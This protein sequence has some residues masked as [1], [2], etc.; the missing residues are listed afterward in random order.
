M[1]MSHLE[2]LQR[3]V[4][5][6]EE[7]D[8]V[9][10]SRVEDEIETWAEQGEDPEVLDY[11]RLH[12]GLTTPWPGLQRGTV[13]GGRYR[14]VRKLGGG[15]MGMVYVAEQ[16]RVEREVA[17]KTINPWAVS[18]RLM[19]RLA[20]EISTLGRMN[21]PNIVRVFDADVHESSSGGPPVLYFTMEIVEGQTLGS[22]LTSREPP[23]LDEKLVCFSGI[24]KAVAFAHERGVIHRDLKPG[25]IMVR[26]DGTPAVLDFGISRV[27]EAHA[28]D[29]ESDE[30][31]DLAG[32]D[33]EGKDDVGS[34]RLMASGTPEY[35]SPAKWRREDDLEAGD[36]F[37]LGVI[38]FEMLTGRRPW[39]FSRESSFNEMREKLFTAKVPP[40]AG[41][42]P[43][44]DQ[45]IDGFV[46]RLLDYDATRRPSAGEALGTVT[47]IIRRRRA[48]A[49]IRRWIPAL[50]AATLVLVG[51]V[52]WAGWE[53]WVHT[54]RLDSEARYRE[55]M[56]SLE[57]PGADPFAEVT[58]ALPF[59]KVARHD[60]AAWR[61]A[62]VR[63]AGSWRVTPG[64]AIDVP[65]G[66]RVLAADQRLESL[67][68]VD[69]TW[70]NP[71]ILTGGQRRVLPGLPSLTAEVESAEFS[72]TGATIAL[73]SRDGRVCIWENDREELTGLGP[74]AT[75]RSAMAFSADGRQF[76]CG[77]ID[78]ENR[79]DA[80]VR[81]WKSGDWE[82]PA[83]LK[84]RIDSTAPL[85]EQIAFRDVRR[86]AFSEDGRYLAAAGDRPYV[87][88]W[89]TSK[90]TVHAVLHHFDAV[91]GIAWNSETDGHLLATGQ[92][93]GVVRVWDLASSRPDEGT[94]RHDPAFTFGSSEGEDAYLKG[95]RPADELAAL[96]WLKGGAEVA[97]VYEG[98]DVLTWG[99][100]RRQAPGRS[101][102]IGEIDEGYR[103]QWHRSGT[104]LTAAS[105]ETGGAIRVWHWED[106]RGGARF[107]LT[108]PSEWVVC[109]GD[110]KL[111]FAGGDRG[112]SVIDLASK[113]AVGTFNESL[114][115]PGAF[116]P[117]SGDLWV[118]TW[119]REIVRVDHTQ[120][121]SSVPREP[122]GETAWSSERSWVRIAFAPA[123]GSVA[124]S[125][126]KVVYFT[127]GDRLAELEKLEG[128]VPSLQL[129]TASD[130]RL[131]LHPDGNW[132]AVETRGEEGNGLYRRGA[133]TPWAQASGFPKLRSASLAFGHDMETI[134][135]LEGAR[136]KRWSLS[137]SAVLDE[138]RVPGLRAAGTRKTLLVAASG[139]PL[140]V[141]ADDTGYPLVL[142]LKAAPATGHLQCRLDGGIRAATTAIAVSPDGKT[143]LVVQPCW[144]GSLLTAWSVGE[145]GKILE[146]LEMAP[147]ELLE[148]APAKR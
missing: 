42:T 24:C 140:V 10:L 46:R 13:I 31:S 126:G 115:G 144:S 62:V 51:L 41:S 15:G 61:D 79:E 8:T 107:F 56:H 134:L 143:V 55:V 82:T 3:I 63:A 23:T 40:L 22:W 72:P 9:P 54:Q 71:S 18:K 90:Q 21:H 33:E 73:R 137:K 127:S 25:N 99:L 138:I 27:R 145:I 89:D 129:S 132:L 96:R 105:G 69:Q 101:F 123:G 75:E 47:A 88:V 2:Q 6:I 49:A 36:V 76:A 80:E 110:G 20:G 118:P 103:W 44:V 114:T 112:G 109:S 66:W 102:R 130:L 77:S 148:S 60:P 39:Q 106:G 94:F 11:L 68:I 43:G 59:A 5:A 84:R 104:V 125:K 78:I 146:E 52:A 116:D 74:V 38:L 117:E 93:D 53:V 119:N 100:W 65:R 26:E 92:R 85:D 97:A 136:L 135:M 86:L 35:M 67:L 37:A 7:L 32:K 64:P 1:N 17:L 131:E 14:I 34:M 139:A 98:G 83:I 12:Y 48:R 16:M 58:G 133:G 142:Y 57:T 113:K 19:H 111:V 121:E 50:G 30:V 4:L 128:G 29:R 124:V 91:N 120:L 122:L 87:F 95:S 28:N 147:V 108:R 141:V 45:R 70:S 81:L